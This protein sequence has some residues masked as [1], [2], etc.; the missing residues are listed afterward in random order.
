MTITAYP[1][2]WPTDWPRTD[3]YNRR[4]GAFKNCTLARARNRLFDELTRIRAADVILSTNIPL[5][6]D[7]EPRGDWRQPADPGV[8]VYFTLRGKSLSMARDAYMRAEH[9]L[10]SLAM[11]VEFLRG[12]ERHG[13]ATM[14]ERAFTGF[15]ALNP[16]GHQ[17]PW[18]TVMSWRPEWEVTVEHIETTFKNLA[19]ERHPDRG[20]SDEKMAELN[21]ARD[22]ALKELQG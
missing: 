16:P 22:E 18:R 20:G 4:A 21:Q 8:A 7:G 6:L 17:H 15:A 14:M 9:N 5:K 11:A 19:M 2:C 10:N 12:L 1:L 3:G 13:G